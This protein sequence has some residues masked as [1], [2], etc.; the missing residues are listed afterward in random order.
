MKRITSIFLLSVMALPLPAFA[1]SKGAMSKQ[2]PSATKGP[3]TIAEPTAFATVE[4][5]S[6]GNGAWVRWEMRN[7]KENL[8][9]YVY[10]STSKGPVSE[11][12]LGAKMKQG[13]SQASGEQYVF[14]DPQGQLGDS[15]YVVAM[16]VDSSEI[17]SSNASA[18]FVER[19]EDVK[20][21]DILRQESVRIAPGRNLV[22]RNLE[23]TSE[24]NQEVRMGAIVPNPTKHRSVIAQT[25]GVKIQARSNGLIRVTRAQLQSAGFDVNSNSANWQLYM[26][27]VELPIILGPSADYIE[28]LGKELDTNESDT[29]AYYLVPGPGAGKRMPVTVA[30]RPLTTVSSTKYSQ[31]FTL[32]Q[33]FNYLNTVLNG[34]AD[35]FWGSII[36]SGGSNIVFNLSGVDR[37]PGTRRIKVD[38]QGYS[39]TQHIVEVTLNG[40]VLPHAE[41]SWTLPF[42]AEYE[43]PVSLLLDGANTLRL[44]STLSGDISLLDK[45]TV[46]FPRTYV[47]QN[48]ELRFYTE[49]YRNARISGFSSSDIKVF[50]ITSES[51]PRIITNLQPTQTEGTWGTVIP[52]ARGR[53]LYSIGA[54]NFATPVAVTAND[55]A[56]LGTSANSGTFLVIAH[57]SLLNEA[58]AW[59][60]YRAGQGTSTKVVSVEEIYDE[61]NYGSLSAN[62]IKAFLDYAKANWQVPP[63]YVLLVGD[64]H[65]DSRNYTGVGYHNMVPSKMVDSLFESTGSDDALAD[66]NNDGLAELAMGRIATR[67]GSTVTIMLNKTIA[68]ESSLTPTSTDRGFLFVHDLPIGYDFGLMTGRMAANLPSGMPKE[69]LDRQFADATTIINSINEIDP[70]VPANSGKYLV[71]WTGH[72][73]S[74]VWATSGYFTVNNVPQMT[75]SPS[76]F[77]SLSC[78]NGYFMGDGDS[79]AEALT[80]A[81]GGGAVAVWAST[82]RTTPDV[83][84][85]MGSRFFLKIGEGTIPR[86]GDLTLDAKNNVAGG[87]D[88]RLSWALIG[89]PMLKVR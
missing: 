50:D 86:L 89:D 22:E 77:T 57:P 41:G 2:V 3:R 64:A 58:Q 76:L 56:L 79:F 59:A 82:A 78:L 71:N 70:S 4:S 32:K 75:N 14:F 1:Q 36:A 24:L 68:W 55:P 84:E 48:N 54:A 10:R 18:N 62:S 88:V 69:T 9:F 13:L 21:G 25:G 85:V 72:G 73:A 49:N 51:E 23:L 11:F 83:Q 47:A 6:E 60:N 35:N 7:E 5:F 34:E 65:Y 74:G 28:F 27:G 42:S 66:F 87:T 80:R 67:I 43:V 81:P 39:T 29:R 31:T 15:Y 40:T 19:I 61:F 16:S 44:R 46:D 63:Q 12:L 45:V 52:S 53:V 37:T 8:G 17:R 20:G 33:R 38:M 30:R 26:Q